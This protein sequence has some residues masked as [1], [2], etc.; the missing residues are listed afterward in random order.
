MAESRRG[1][2][3]VVVAVSL[4]VLAAAAAVTYVATRPREETS[5]STQPA[6]GP[7]TTQAQSQPSTQP[8]DKQP[9]PKG[10]TTTYIDVIRAHHPRMPQTQPM[11]VPVDLSQAARVVFSEPIYLSPRSDLWITRPDAPPTPEVLA[12]A[13]KEQNEQLVLAIREHV[14]FAHWTP[15]EEGPWSFTLVV[16]GE[17]GG[18]EV[19]TQSDRTPIP[20]GRIY[21]WDRALDWGDKVVVATGTGVSVIRFEPEF[22]EQHYDLINPAAS[23]D[24]TYAEPQFLMDWEGILAWVPWEGKKAGSDGAARFVN[25]KW[26]PLGPEQGWPDKLLH[27]V[28]LYDGGV[29]QLV[30][31]DDGEWVKLAF[32]TLEK[33]EVDEAKVA[34]LVE[35]LSDPEDKTRQAAFSELTRYGA[36]AWPVLERMMPDQGPEA[37]ARLRQLLKNRVDPTLGGMSLLGDKLRLVNRLADGGAVFY[38]EVGVAT[39]GEGEEPVIR[40]PAWIG[41]RP[42]QAVSLLDP[43]FTTDLDPDRSRIYA[44]GADWIVVNNPAAGPQRFVGNGFE[45]LLRKSEL[46]F[47]EPYGIDRRGRW[48]FRRPRDGG[49]GAATAPAATAPVSAPATASAT[50]PASAPATGPTGQP[51]DTLILDPTIPDPKPRL[52]V[53]TYGTADVVGWDRNNWPAVKKGGSWALHGLGWSAM[54]R[55]DQLFTKPEEVPP[56][57]AASAAVGPAGAVDPASSTTSPTTTASTIAPTTSTTS[58]TTTTAPSDDLGPPILVDSDATRYHDGRTHLRVVRRA[59]ERTDWPLPPEATGS[60]AKVHLVR[61]S[62]GVLFLYNQPGRILRIRPTPD[63]AEPFVVEA[64]FTRNIPSADEI[65]RLW[66]DPAGR[67]IMAYGNKLAIMFPGGYIPPEIWHKIPPSQLEPEE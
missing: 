32:T 6:T 53:W 8:R 16:R 44:F 23:P 10:P 27:L 14:V 7:A 15:Q 67:M 60:L 59:G 48:L 37:Q 46:A 34:T 22:Q 12:R 29:L 36:S 66:I 25:D 1:N 11:G 58:P 64:T 63:E 20:T 51:G 39:A 13:I 50:S 4:A 35:Q 5:Q 47:N 26:S 42:G 43:F 49:G 61:T 57:A 17:G 55:G 38:A 28:P 9:K 54:K 62:E 18:Y 40:S 21:H 2:A 3:R 65:T 31:S 19:V 45:P 52:P 30:P 41:V 56:G 24:T 33:L